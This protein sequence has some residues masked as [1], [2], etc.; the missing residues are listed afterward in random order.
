MSLVFLAGREWNLRPDGR[1]HLRF[2]DVGQGDSALV[3]LP[4][5]RTVLIDGGPDWSTLEEL[6]EVL[7]FFRRHIDLLVLSHPNLDHLTSFPEILKRYRVGSILFAGT[8]NPLPRYHAMMA[9]A[10]QEGVTLT[11]VH[12]GQSMDLGDGA[13][14]EILWPP[15]RLPKGFSKDANNVSVTMKLVYEDHSA[16]FTGDMEKPVEETLVRSRKTDLASEI[17]KVAHHGSRGSSGTGFLLAVHPKLAVVSVGKDNSYGH[18]RKE[19]ID[20]LQALGAKVWRTDEGG[21]LEVIW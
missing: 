12:A 9:L 11:T 21:S 19:V 5:G 6:G 3:T 7:P 15:A 2:F 8:D 16:L 13:T 18:P 4:S 10:K 20:R 17:L 1:L 14:L